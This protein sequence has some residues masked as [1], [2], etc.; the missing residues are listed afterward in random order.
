MHVQRNRRRER[1]KLARVFARKIRHREQSTLLPK[2]RV[3]KARNVAHVNAAADDR[4]AFLRRGERARNERA[5]GREDQRDVERL[6]R[7]RVGI[8]RRGRAERARE[9]RRRLIAGPHKC[10]SRLP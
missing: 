4:A 6:W 7:G 5:D 10:M 3:W 1:K 9:F 8:L 2:Q